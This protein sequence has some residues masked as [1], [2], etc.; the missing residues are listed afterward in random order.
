MSCYL[1]SKLTAKICTVAWKKVCH[2]YAEAG[3]SLRTLSNINSSL[4]LHLCWNFLS[5]ND[6][7][8][9]LCH[10]RFIKDGIP[11]HSFRRSS[12]WY[13]VVNPKFLNL[14]NIE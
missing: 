5:S 9:R 1:L 2:P 14:K 4:M 8:A 11:V 3:L 12:V 10:I 6:Q 13:G 7:L